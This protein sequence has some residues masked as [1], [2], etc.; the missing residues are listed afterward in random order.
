M[1]IGLSNR[2]RFMGE[3]M[4][5]KKCKSCREPFTPMRPMQVACSPGCAISLAKSKLA[6]ESKD[7]AKKSKAKDRA[8]LDELKSVAEL[9]KEAQAE[10]N[11][12]IRLRDRQLGCASCDKPSG[13]DG[14]WHASHYRSVGAAPQLRF[15][16]K[17]V[18]KA[19][20]VCNNHLSG[21]ISGYRPRLIERVGIEAVEALECNNDIKRYTREYA[22]RVK[23]IFAKRCRMIEKRM[24]NE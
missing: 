16:T 23:S 15:N 8:R 17:N 2:K 3:G 13:W 22:K 21:N 11:R 18:H 24:R 9:L 12:Y 20:S 7:K 19:C 5:D 6:K 1:L 4:K 14:Q 10:F